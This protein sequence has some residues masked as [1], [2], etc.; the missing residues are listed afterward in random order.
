MIWKHIRGVRGDA[1]AFF[2]RKFH[3]TLLSKIRMD[4]NLEKRWTDTRIAE[5][6]HNQG[7]LKVGNTY[8]SGQ[9]TIDQALHGLPRLLNCCLRRPY[10]PIN[11]PPTAWILHFRINVFLSNWKV[12]VEHVEIAVYSDVAR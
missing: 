10:F 9:T 6:I 1:D 11:V 3:K 8:G 4:L 12:H 2:V 7:P 5:K